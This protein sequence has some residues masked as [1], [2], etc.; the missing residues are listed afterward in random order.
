MRHVLDGAVCERAAE[1]AGCPNLDDAPVDHDW[2]RQPSG[3]WPYLTDPDSKSS[4]TAG[5][6]HASGWRN[7]AGLP[8]AVSHA[9]DCRHMVCVRC[10]DCEAIHLCAFAIVM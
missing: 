9:C 10:W 6:A 7:L 5:T 2:A 4:R 1:I 8:W 3:L